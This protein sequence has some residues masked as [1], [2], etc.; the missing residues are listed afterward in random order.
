MSIASLELFGI[1]VGGL[2][3][4]F[5]CVIVAL[6]GMSFQKIFDMVDADLVDIFQTIKPLKMW[7]WLII[8]LLTTLYLAVFILLVLGVAKVIVV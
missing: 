2:L 6:D 5:A 8:A 1:F 7:T 3:N 4:L